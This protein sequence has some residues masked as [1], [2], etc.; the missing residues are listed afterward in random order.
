MIVNRLPFILKQKGLSIRE[1][2]RLTGITYTTIRAVY[3]GH[4]RSVQIEVLDSLCR[5]L[6]LQPGDVY[7]YYPDESAAQS[8]EDKILAYVEHFEDQRETGSTNGS[9]SRPKNDDQ[10][11]SWHVW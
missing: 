3:H 9:T 8:A 6:D 5:V 4:R 7:K 2:S 11:Q 10:G 1:L